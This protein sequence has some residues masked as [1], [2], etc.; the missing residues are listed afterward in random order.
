VISG[1]GVML[2]PTTLVGSYSQPIWLIDQAK[3]S[4]QVPRVRAHD[5]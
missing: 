4:K 2:L 1:A 5:L 3:L